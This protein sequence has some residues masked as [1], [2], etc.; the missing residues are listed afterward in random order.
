[1]NYSSLAQL[2]FSTVDAEYHTDDDFCDFVT[3][4]WGEGLTELF[5]LDELC[6]LRDH[7]IKQYS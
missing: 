2:Y 5:T 3:H 6:F 7:F 4:Q 1:M